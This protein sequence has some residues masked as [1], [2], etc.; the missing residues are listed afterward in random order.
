MSRLK[1][2]TVGRSTTYVCEDMDAG[3]PLHAHPPGSGLEHDVTCLTGE[4][5][6]FVH[7]H[8]MYRLRAG[9]RLEFDATLWHSVRPLIEGTSFVNTAMQEQEEFHSVLNS[10]HNSQDWARKFDTQMLET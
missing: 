1:A 4:L 5:L 8:T 7:P 3:L 9:D 10:P 2:D 6:V